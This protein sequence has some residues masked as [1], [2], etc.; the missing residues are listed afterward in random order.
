MKWI[1]DSYLDLI[2]DK[3]LLSDEKSICNALPTTWYNATYPG[4]WVQ[5]TPYVIGDLVHP[6]TQNSF[7]YE[8]IADGTSGV[9]EPPWGV[10]QDAEFTDGTA[11]WK[12]HENYALVNVSLSPSDF[13]KGDGDTD[14]RKLT[15]SQKIGALVHTDG[16]VSHMAYLESS[17]KAIHYIRSVATIDPGSDDIVSGRTTLFPEDV[18]T[19]RDPI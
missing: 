17:T 10:A 6:P 14:G 12:S 3:I 18:I 13:A 4:L 15:V 5:N 9:T 2:L 8:C 7:I 16:T 19:I 1:P 11:E